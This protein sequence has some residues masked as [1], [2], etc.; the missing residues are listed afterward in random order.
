MSVCES[1]L[2]YEVDF[3]DTETDCVGSDGSGSS[4]VD[5]P[6]VEYHVRIT[7]NKKTSKKK[8]LEMLYQ[9]NLYWN[10][11]KHLWAYEISEKGQPHLHGAIVMNNKYNSGTM[12]KFMAKHKPLLEGSPGYY[13]DIVK[14]SSRNLAYCAKDEDIMLTNYTD[15]ELTNIKNKI[16]AIQ[17][18]MKT[19]ATA[20]VLNHLKKFKEFHSFGHIKRV[21]CELYVNEWDKLPPVNVKQMAIYCTIK[22]GLLQDCE[23]EINI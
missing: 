21:I 3:I 11:K 7:L 18:D 8:A 22:L 6:G 15:E 16:L 5:P 4:K 17:E 19:S 1:E 2:S 23:L 9:Y 10:V 12:S 13:H 14:D 20:K